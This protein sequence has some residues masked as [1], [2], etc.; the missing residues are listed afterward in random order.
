M[1]EVW[2]EVVHDGYADYE[3]SSLGRVR[4]NKFNRQKVLKQ[5]S[6]VDKRRNSATHYQFVNL[7]NN[8]KRVRALV[9]RLVAGA[10][11]ENLSGLPEVNHK[12]GKKD[13]NVPDNL[14]WTTRLGNIQHGH[15]TGLVPPPPHYSGEDN[16]GAKL[17]LSQVEEIRVLPKKKQTGI[18]ERFGVSQSLISMI[19]NGR[20]WQ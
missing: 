11:I 9:H 6:L 2:E 1:I 17:T 5:M 15:A 13:H 10:F 4:S 20:I 12:D 3:V 16:S 14:E 8:G 19:K 7:F 18:A